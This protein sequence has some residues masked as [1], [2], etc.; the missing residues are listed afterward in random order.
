MTLAT[1][2]ND[3]RSQQILDKLISIYFAK[4]YGIRQ[5]SV[6]EKEFISN[7][8]FLCVITQETRSNGYDDENWKNYLE[9]NKVYT[10]DTMSVSQ[11]SSRIHL[12]EVP[13]RSFNSVIF[14]LSIQEK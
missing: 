9:L 11:S 10:L 2:F 1:I 5:V 6:E 8:T 4:D 14:E 3:S 12:K 13:N 7:N